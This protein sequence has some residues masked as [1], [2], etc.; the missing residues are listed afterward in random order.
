MHVYRMHSRV[1]DLPA[2]GPGGGGQASEMSPALSNFI[3]IIPGPIH[4]GCHIL[5]CHAASDAQTMDIQ[6]YVSQ[7]S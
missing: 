4:R 1:K 3:I 7:E 2:L 5:Q 6:H